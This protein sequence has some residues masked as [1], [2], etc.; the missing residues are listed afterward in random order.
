MC[1][2][3]TV[4]WMNENIKFVPKN[5]NPHNVPQERSIENLWGCLAQKV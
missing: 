3:K 4:S 5:I 1:E 2:E